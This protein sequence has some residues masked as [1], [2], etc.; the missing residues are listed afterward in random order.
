MVTKPK[1]VSTPAAA[2]TQQSALASTTAVTS[3]VVTT[4]AQ[5]PTPA[6]LWRPLPHQHPSLQHQRQHL[7]NL[8]LLVQLNKRNLEKSQQRH[9]WLTSTDSKSGDSSP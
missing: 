4:V 2:T 9:Q 6:L 8:H 7:L 3:S 5:A 1:A